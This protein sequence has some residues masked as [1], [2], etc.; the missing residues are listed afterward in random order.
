MN[1]KLVFSPT[2]PYTHPFLPALGNKYDIGGIIFDT[3]FCKSSIYGE[4]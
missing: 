3:S 1:A 2:K 4:V